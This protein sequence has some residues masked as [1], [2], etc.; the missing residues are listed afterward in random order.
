MV[1]FGKPDMLSTKTRRHINRKVRVC[2][3]DGVCVRVCVCACKLIICCSGMFL[4]PR[5]AF[6]VASA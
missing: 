2:V 4:W 6:M 1:G 5:Q 3:H